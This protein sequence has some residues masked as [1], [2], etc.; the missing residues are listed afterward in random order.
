M[1]MMIYFRFSNFIVRLQENCF[2]HIQR[3]V[4]NRPTTRLALRCVRELETELSS[5]VTCA[6]REGHRAVGG[7]DDDVTSR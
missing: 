6:L 1:M 2:L 5:F 7:V 4:R 3:T